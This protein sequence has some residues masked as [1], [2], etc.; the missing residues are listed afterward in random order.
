M[1]CAYLAEVSVGLLGL[2]WE[3]LGRWLGS[4]LGKETLEMQRK[5]DIRS[6]RTVTHW[7]LLVGDTRNAL[8]GSPN[9]AH[10]CSLLIFVG[11]L[12]DV[13]L[14]HDHGPH[15]KTVCAL[16]EWYCVVSLLTRTH[17]QEVQGDTEANIAYTCQLAASFLRT[18]MHLPFAR[19]FRFLICNAHS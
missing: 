6:P 16:H 7:T 4:A 11:L 10:V 17:W 1:R 5:K 19:Y 15:I 18:C 2:S 8:E 12:R 14:G 13:S 9:I 3:M